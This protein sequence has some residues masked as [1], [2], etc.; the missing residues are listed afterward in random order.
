MNYFARFEEREGHLFR[1]DTRV[2]IDSYQP[3][4]S[5]R[6][7]A[8]II[9]KNPG[10]AKPS[11]KPSKLGSLE[12]L[13]LNGDNFLPCVRNRFRDAFQRQGSPPPPNAFV[14][15][16]NL[17]YLCSADLGK[18]IKDHESM[19]SSAICESENEKVPITWF[20][21]GGNDQKLNPIK[22]RFL[23]KGHIAPFFY[24]NILKQ[25]KATVPTEMD[26]ARHTQGMPKEPVI[27][28]LSRTL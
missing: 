10:S 11:N 17:F 20:A 21:W 19:Q 4:T 5:E 8:A 25:V 9:G 1:F 23:R 3:D 6:C 28:H 22:N 14:R 7:I 18:A 27:T 13:E 24:D 12:A 26:S 16:W 15:V 2:Y